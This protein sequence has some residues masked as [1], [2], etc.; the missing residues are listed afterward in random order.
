MATT[1]THAMAEML[2]L[3]DEQGRPLAGV[4]APVGELRAKAL[5]HGVAHVWIWRKH[6]GAS[7]VLVQRRSADKQTW[8]N[9]YDVSAAGHMRVAEAPIDAGVREA[10]EEI[11]ITVEPSMLRNFG[12]VRDYLDSGNGTFE[13]EFQWLYSL[14]LKSDIQ[15]KLRQEEVGSLTW[16]PL[17]QFRA[18]CMGARYL[19]HSKLYYETVLSNFDALGL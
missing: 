18:E 19:P 5:L 15:F 9:L 1:E 14:E 11:G 2:Q 13:N 3:Y 4:S 10:Y 17:A 7:Q 6:N 8:P 12:V 16:V